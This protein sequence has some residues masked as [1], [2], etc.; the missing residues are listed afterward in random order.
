MGYQA[1]LNKAW[2]ELKKISPQEKFSL[3]LL[4]DEYEIDTRS[5]KVLS[6]SCNTQVKDFLVILILHYLV[7]KIN[8]LPEPCQDWIS[9]RQLPGGLGYYPAFRK[10]T[11]EPIIRK[12]GNNPQ[13]LFTCLDRFPGKKI[14]YGDSGIV[15]D[16]LESVSF[17]I[18]VFAAYEEFSAEANMFFDN[19]ISQVFCSEDIAVLAAYVAGQI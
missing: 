1:A 15:I 10:R 17:L 3:R 4:S 5:G 12:Y 11:L 6:L 9:F 7:K 2:G 19:S 18:T 8:G 14:Q 13:S 16:V